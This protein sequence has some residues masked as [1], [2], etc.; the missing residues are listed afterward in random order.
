MSDEEIAAAINDAVIP[1]IRNLKSAERRSEAA[2]YLLSL[3]YEL[4]FGMEG[5]E[6]MRGWLDQALEDIELNV[7]RVVI[8]EF[9]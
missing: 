2:S 3:G 4:T 7:P 8:R 6:F 5:K 1:I 9:Q